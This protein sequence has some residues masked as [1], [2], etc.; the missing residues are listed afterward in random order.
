MTTVAEPP[1]LPEPEQTPS[2]LPAERSTRPPLS[3]DRLTLNLVVA[4]LIVGVLGSLWWIG[5]GPVSLWEGRQDVWNL[6][7]RMWPP[8]LE[9]PRLVWDQAIETFF[10]AFAGT[11]MGVIL[12][13]P[14]A[15]LAASNITKNRYLRGAARALIVVAR[16]LPELLLALIF[17]RVYS[18]GPLAG[19]VA[20]GLHS[21]G[22]LGKLFAD[23]IEQIEEG[24]REGVAATGAGGVQ[25]FMTGV[26]PQ[27]VPSFVAISLYR[28]DINFRA[29]T[30]LGL[31]G[32]GGIGLSI[33]AHQGSLDYPQLLGVALVIV[34]LIL[35]VEIVSTSIRGMIL[36]HGNSRGSSL[37]K[38]L[39]RTPDASTFQVAE[40]SDGAAA[41]GSTVTA[42]TSR[43][44][45]GEN[46]DRESLRPPWTRGRITMTAFAAVTMV[47]LVLS[48]IIPEMSF[49]EFVRG[50]PQIPLTFE[51]L[52]PWSAFVDIPTKALDGDIAFWRNQFFE[53]LVETVAI[54]LGATGLALLFALPTAVLA[55]RNIAPARW[56]YQLS[57]LFILLVRALPDLVVAVIFVAALGLGPK[58]GVIALA[59][60]IYGFGTKLFADNLEEIKEGPRDGVRSTG[61]SGPQELMTS[62]L[63]QAMPSIV[64]NSLYM[65]DVSIRAST[66][67]GIVGAG[68]IGFALLQGM[69]LLRWELVGGLLICVFIIVYAIEQL[70]VWIRKQII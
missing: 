10:M 18:I 61:A 57:R 19:V 65:L 26:W 55:A 35:V 14:T 16:A 68:G 27:V 12:A 44:L 17:V 24:Q 34:A 28:L 62:A 53:P 40:A 45:V 47:L 15:I 8:R 43:Q 38:W 64:S 1:V 30:L 3:R 59:I 60:G 49:I 6:L 50:M 69:K 13:I 58:A 23:S 9:E 11:A 63:P 25:E 22:M 52:I 37:D 29:S 39:R 5:L 56:V 42:P 46:F 41:N 20:I 54:G 48:F 21:I 4:G 36:G 67:L 2:E 31:V 51:R 70:S 33:R 32:A 7:Q 66:V